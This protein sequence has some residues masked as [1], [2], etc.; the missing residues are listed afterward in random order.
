MY[1]NNRGHA[2]HLPHPFDP[3]VP[4]PPAD[5]PSGP[6]QLDQGGSK[7]AAKGKRTKGQKVKGKRKQKDDTEEVYGYVDDEDM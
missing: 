2:P 4:L 1:A 3:T 7:K 6:T 5:K